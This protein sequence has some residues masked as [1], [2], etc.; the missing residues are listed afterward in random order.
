M[1]KRPKIVLGLALLAF[2]FFFLWSKSLSSKSGLISTFQISSRQNKFNIS[3]NLT[4]AD[5]SRFENA[6]AA[7]KLPASLEKGASFELDS[8]SSAQ[9]AYVSPVKGKMNFVPSGINFSGN[10]KRIAVPA[11]LTFQTFNFPQNL[12][13]AFSGTNLTNMAQDYLTLPA[14]LADTITK[15]SSPDAQVVASFGQEPNTVYIFKT[16]NFDITSLKEMTSSGEYKQETQDGVTLYI[17]KNITAFEIG[18]FSFIT[19][20]LDSAKAIIAATKDKK[21]VSFPTEKEG[22]VSLLYLNT[23]KN[24]VPQSL[25]NKI[26]NSPKKVPTF[27]KNISRLTFH[28]KDKSFTG[29]IETK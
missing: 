1:A 3:F 28:L 7:L 23:D 17:L 22:I 27:L 9:L 29:S 20:N 26:F 16:G 18:D 6:L 21:H 14:N 25:L 24:P 4:N 19:S 10:P 5:K 13:F 12:N 8:T 15:D 11:N 2:I